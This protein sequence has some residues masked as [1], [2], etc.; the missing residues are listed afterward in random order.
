MSYVWIFMWSWDDSKF[1]LFSFS[2]ISARNIDHVCKSRVGSLFLA[3]KSW[4]GS[5]FELLL[6]RIQFLFPGYVSYSLVD[7][8]IEMRLTKQC[9]DMFEL[10]LSHKIC[11]LIQFQISFLRFSNRWLPVKIRIS[12]RYRLNDWFRFEIDQRRS[13]QHFN[14]D[15]WKFQIGIISL[16]SFTFWQIELNQF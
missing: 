3:Q 15:F 2:L 13:S 12:I 10:T 5:K 1:E 4:D 11:Q 14:F 6:P 8:C 16:W 7:V 9:F